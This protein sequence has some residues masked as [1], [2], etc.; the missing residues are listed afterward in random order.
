MLFWLLPL[1]FL[2]FSCEKDLTN[3]D[4]RS[5]PIRFFTDKTIYTKS[6]SLYLHLENH[7]NNDITIVLRCGIYLKMYYQKKLDGGWSEKLCFWYMS[8]RCPT[9]PDTVQSQ[10]TFHHT[11]PAD[12]FESGGTFRLLFAYHPFRQDTIGQLISNTFAITNNSIVW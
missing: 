2:I 4:Y 6:D 12:Y 7:S 9:I 10:T 11:L 1:L 5:D 3:V 8:L